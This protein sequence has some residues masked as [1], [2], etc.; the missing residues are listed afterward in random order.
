MAERDLKRLAAGG[1]QWIAASAVFAVAAR[2]ILIL[3]VARFLTPEEIGLYGMCVLV[4]GFAEIFMEAGFGSSAVHFQ[5]TSHRQLS[6][7]YWLNVLSG[8]VM[9]A[10]I[11]AISPL[12]APA[13]GQPALTE[14]IPLCAATIAIH[15]FGQPFQFH[16]QRDLAFLHIALAEVLA[17]SVNAVVAV[18]L[19]ASGLGVHA[20][21]A[22]FIAFALA[23]SGA[24]LVVGI[25]RWRPGLTFSF[26]E[27]RQQ[28]SFSAF[29][30]G[31]RV[32]NYLR[33]RSGEIAVSLILGA[34]AMGY[35]VL[36][37]G[38]VLRPVNRLGPMIN[39]VLFP[40]LA[41]VQGEVDR[42]RR[43]YRFVLK[44]LL[45]GGAPA[46]LGLVAVAP[47]V[48]EVLLGPQWTP[49]APV[50]QGL[51]VIAL[52]QL[53]ILPNAPL[54]LGMGRARRA[55]TYNLV[56]ASVQFPAALAAFHFF[57]LEGGIWAL[58]A[59]HL[60]QVPLGYWFVARPLCRLEPTGYLGVVWTIVLGALAMALCVALVP[61]LLRLDPAI[62]MLAAQVGLG[63]ALYGAFVLLAERRFLVEVLDTA[64]LIRGPHQ[65][66]A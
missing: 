56:G 47:L 51:G 40:T 8:L 35:Y 24:L 58:A 20:L 57:V 16:L 6:T 66:P 42:L 27:S 18:A 62:L 38:I 53:M 61:T 25:R 64:G 41:K 63:I 23:R 36:A 7:L 48:I 43:A 45:L 13:F 50:L 1:A 3:V 17:S 44:L 46:I 39:R 22:G 28:I 31:A 10:I 26:A 54:M 37:H 32:M 4:V 29:H 19:A 21:I 60:L 59:L 30:M 14:L 15:A 5:D 9:L 55:F 65:G 11:V 34:E 49:A 2:A 52:C 33:I 12:L